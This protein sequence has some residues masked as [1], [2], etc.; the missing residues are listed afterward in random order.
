MLFMS[1]PVKD[2][3]L[4]LGAKKLIL[5]RLNTNLTQEDLDSITTSAEADE[6]ITFEKEEAKKNTASHAQIKPAGVPNLDNT[7]PNSRINGAP[8]EEPYSEAELNDPL[9]PDVSRCN[10][11]DPEGRILKFYSQEFPNGRLI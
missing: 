7:N 6:M 8:S 2:P 3:T 10:K 5:K 11:A 4:G 9:Q 1:Q